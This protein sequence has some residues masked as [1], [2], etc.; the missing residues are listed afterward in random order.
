MFVNTTNSEK[1]IKACSQ[2]G[3]QSRSKATSWINN[4][5]Q[6]SDAMYCYKSWR[7]TPEVPEEVPIA[8]WE[9][10]AN[11]ENNRNTC[12]II[13][14]WLLIAHALHVIYEWMK[15][16]VLNWARATLQIVFIL[17]ADS[18]LLGR[19][20]NFNVACEYHPRLV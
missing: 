4:W 12:M 7:F 17:T 16:M 8:S 13:N 9:H 20:S 18:T 3:F 5:S 19:R 6:L 14:R 11:L 10:C 15:W 2:C 1:Y